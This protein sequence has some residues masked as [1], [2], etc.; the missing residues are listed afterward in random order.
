VCPEA[1]VPQGFRG[2]NPLPRTIENV[3]R[4]V[5]RRES[6]DVSDFVEE[7]DGTV[8]VDSREAHQQLHVWSVNCFFRDLGCEFVDG[9]FYAFELLQITSR[10][11]FSVGENWRFRSHSRPCLPNMSLYSLRRSYLSRRL[12]I[13]FLIS[14]RVLSGS[15]GWF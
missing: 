13:R 11:V 1:P 2:S 4:L 10:M 15:I 5:S 9:V 3:L 8:I 12:W 7:E 14:V 6:D